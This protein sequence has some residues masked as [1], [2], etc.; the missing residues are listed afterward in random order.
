MC[1]PETSTWISNS[2]LQPSMSNTELLIS[3]HRT[4]PFLVNANSILL[5]MRPQTLELSFFRLQIQQIRIFCW[6]YFQ[7]I[8]RELIKDFFQLQPWLSNCLFLTRAARMILLKLKS[9]YITPLL[10][11]LWWFPILLK[12]KP[13][14]SHG[15]I[16]LYWFLPMLWPRFLPMLWP[17][18][19]P[20]PTVLTL[21]PPFCS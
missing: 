20:S 1:P 8:S 15:S 16:L 9:D 18:L 11:T 14:S 13:K 6:T 3:F 2:D 7:I 12:V 21:W 4:A 5:I 19:P 10:K 17:H